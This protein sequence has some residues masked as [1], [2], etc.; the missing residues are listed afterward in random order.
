MPWWISVTLVLVGLSVLVKFLYVL[1]TVWVIRTTRG[2]LFVSTPS[3][4][5]QAALNTVSMER[6]ELFVDLG[7][8]SGKV[9]RAFH[10]RY[11]VRALGFEINPMAYL[12]ARL[13]CV[14]L[15][16]VRVLWRDFWKADIRDAD[17]VFLYL[18]P[19]V[20]QKTAEKLSKELKEGTRVISYNFPLPGWT[21][22]R[23]PI[24]KEVSPG[25]TLYLYL[26]PDAF[27]DAEGSLIQQ[28]RES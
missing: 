4:A 8:G 9:L 1:C 22:C 25:G 23:C 18:F 20:M 5:I 13:M 28:R 2:A 7:C 17:V 14:G 15:S 3:R 10:R 24:P 19:D 12:W 11:G 27:D 16:R 21:P 6:D 26:V